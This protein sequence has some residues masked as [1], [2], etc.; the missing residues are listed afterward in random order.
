MKKY[1]LLAALL[2]S[3]INILQA[4]SLI[5]APDTVCIRQY[6]QLRTPDSIGHT[7]YWS[8]CSGYILNAPT[9]T[10]MGAGFSF[11]TPSDILIQKDGSKYYG[12]VINYANNELLRL[13]YGASLGNT[14][15]VTSLGNV[16]GKMPVNP[17]SMYLVKDSIQNF[18]FM[19]VTGGTDVASSSLARLDFRGSLANT[20]NIAN[21]G[22]LGSVLNTPKGLFVASEGGN[23]YG[24][25]MNDATNTLVRFDM[26]NNISITPSFQDLGNIGGLFNTPTDIAPI[27]D[28][29]NWYFFVTNQGDNTLFRIDF[30]GSLTN[31][32]PA[33]TTLGNPGS[34]LSG[35]SAISIIKDCSNLYAFVTNQS[36][37]TL[38][39]IQMG[40]VTGPFAGFSYGA[41]GSLYKPAGLSRVIRDHDNINMFAVNDSTNTL[42][43]F[44]FAQCTAASIPSSTSGNPP[45]FRYV[46]TGT[47]NVY[48]LEDEGLP[49]QK[50]DCEQIY[51]EDIPHI[52]LSHDTTICQ[53][54]SVILSVISPNALSYTFSPVYNLSDSQG[55]NLIAHPE[56]SLTY[57]IIIPYPDGCIV[58]TG[59]TINVSK[60]KADAGQDRTISDGAST[61]LGGPLTSLGIGYTY[62]WTPQQYISNTTVSDPTANPPNDFTY[63]LEVNEFNDGLKCK[64]RDTVVIRVA[65]ENIYLP[66]AFMPGSGDG[67]NGRFGLL[68]KQVIQLNY[69]RI[70]DRWGEEVFTTTNPAQQWDGMFNNK[71]APGGVYVWEVDGFC[72]SGKRFKRSG[73]VTLIR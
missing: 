60:V 73:N 64:S 71:I 49:T 55:E 38:A 52:I 62:T 7:Y 53:G 21:F 57:K 72:L 70:F 59:I 32:T 40:S 48:Y 11:N 3:Q 56:Y 44:T 6:I 65:C 26:G 47:Y 23:W 10:N 15:V 17:S 63:Y 14:P 27:Y 58:D 51:V 30:G 43:R 34:V 37:N 4:Q 25:T 31:L 29:G 39:Q 20:P 41:S 28:A 22:N 54:D 5:I 45:K 46:T 66:N 1:L 42:S 35:P 8:F 36:S 33:A 19:F 67:S 24:F 13:D 61:V 16:D 50:S 68:N 69:F 18:W 12:F 2:V 9:G